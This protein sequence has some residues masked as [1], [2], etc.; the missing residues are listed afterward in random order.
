MLAPWIQEAKERALKAREGMIV[1]DSSHPCPPYRAA[2]FGLGAYC[3]SVGWGESDGHG[4]YWIADDE[5]A[6]AN[7]EL[8]AH[9]RDD[10][11]K[12]VELLESIEKELV[13]YNGWAQYTA[14]PTKVEVI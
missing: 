9:A 3:E 12:M 13:Y 7:A 2:V 5:C 4:A 6:K 10:I 1:I 14:E 8:L 11:L